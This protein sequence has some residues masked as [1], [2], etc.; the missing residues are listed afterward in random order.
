MAK[1]CE[2]VIYLSFPPPELSITSYLVIVS[3]HV[4]HQFPA[5]GSTRSARVVAGLV[6]DIN[7]PEIG[8]H[9]GPQ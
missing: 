4:R 7:K 2:A 3:R 5:S 8:G 6:H 1:L 9:G